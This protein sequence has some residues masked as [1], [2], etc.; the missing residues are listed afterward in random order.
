MVQFVWCLIYMGML[1]V[2]SH[3]IGEALPR[4][5]FQYDAAPYRPYDWE[6]GGRV[7]E[8]IGIRRWKDHMPDMSRVMR[9]MMPKR[10]SWGVGAEQVQRL[11][12]ETCVAEMIHRVLCVF[13]VGI[14]FIMPTGMGLFL[15]ALYIL[16]F[17]VPFIIIQRYN[18]PQLVRLVER[19]EARKVR[20]RNACADSVM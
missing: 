11:I 9:D 6:R 3:Y 2:L 12:A 20:I 15:M 19:L 14:Y 13:S 10:L 7:Y 8:K 5:W 18:R 1:G 4:D 17:N 16:V